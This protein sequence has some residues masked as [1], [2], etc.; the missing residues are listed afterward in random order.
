MNDFAHRL[1]GAIEGEPEADTEVVQF[2]ADAQLTLGI[3]AAVVNADG[4]TA[5]CHLDSDDAAFV[6]F[7]WDELEVEWS[8]WRELGNHSAD[9]DL[10]LSTVVV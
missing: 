4:V 5:L 8:A 9:D 3:T 7:A 10:V 2:W 1:V 6:L